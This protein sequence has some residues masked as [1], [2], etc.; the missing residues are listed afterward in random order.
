MSDDLELTRQRRALLEIAPAPLP[1]H[2]AVVSLSADIGDASVRLRYV[3]DR[4]VLS[5]VAFRTYLNAA[6]DIAGTRPESLAQTILE[7]V[8]DQVI[9]CW[10]EVT[11]TAAKKDIAHQVRIE[12][13]Q[14]KWQDRGLLDRLEP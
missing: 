3:P 2:D 10:L 4:D 8:N 9:P 12:D 11:L 1:R 14:P 13:R 5:P 7:D 6:A